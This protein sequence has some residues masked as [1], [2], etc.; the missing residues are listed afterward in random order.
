MRQQAKRFT[1][2]SE[3]KSLP[4]LNLCAVWRIELDMLD[5]AMPIDASE[6]DSPAD[7][8]DAGLARA[9]ARGDR[10]AYEAIYRRHSPR[11]YAVVWWLCGGNAARADDVL[12][13]TFIA[14]WKAL[15]QF[16]F[17]VRWAPGCIAWRSTPP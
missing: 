2:R 16:R 3:K 7:R 4:G 8:D 17:R 6:C 12:Q 9:A 1:P 11:L 5:T 15:P 13:E 14:A 10:I